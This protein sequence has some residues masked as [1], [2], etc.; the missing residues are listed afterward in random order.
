M[1]LPR[2]EASAISIMTAIG[3]ITTAL[4]GGMYVGAL[5]NEVDTLK[6]EKQKVEEI[7]EEV[8]ENTVAVARVEVRQEAILRA[9]VVQDKKLDKILEKLEEMD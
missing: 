7:Q 9:Q 3:L 1:T 5:A 4:G 2:K 6:E 8:K